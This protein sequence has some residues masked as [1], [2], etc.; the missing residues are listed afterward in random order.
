MGSVSIFAGSVYGNAQHVAEEVQT[1]LEA[2]GISCE[3]FT[4]PDVSDFTDAE[5]VLVITSTT[6]QGDIPPNLELFHAELRETFPLMD[7]KPFAVV[8]LGDSSYGE[9][10]CG[11]GRQFF[12][13]LNELQGKAISE[14]L[15]VDAM[16]TLSPEEEVVPWVKT[17]IE[18]LTQA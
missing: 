18:A 2:E 1:M 15:E 17:Q 4:D 5:S 13:L 11:G 14:M 10:Y 6:G 8:G 9:S 12:E 16:E 3:V 7:G